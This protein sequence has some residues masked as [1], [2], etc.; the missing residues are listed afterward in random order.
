MTTK[1]KNELLEISKGLSDMV[2]GEVQNLIG[3]VLLVV[4]KVPTDDDRDDVK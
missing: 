1:R 3:K 4:T 2:G